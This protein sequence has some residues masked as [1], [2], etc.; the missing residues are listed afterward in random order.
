MRQ[1]VTPLQNYGSFAASWSASYTAWSPWRRSLAEQT[2]GGQCYESGHADETDHQLASRR[3]RVAQLVGT[4]ARLASALFYVGVWD[5]QARLRRKFTLLVR[6]RPPR[7][8]VAQYDV[9]QCLLRTSTAYSK[10]TNAGASE[11]TRNAWQCLA[12]SPR[13]AP[14]CLSL[15]HISEPTRPY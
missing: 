2:G 9:R 5:G 10:P 3:R 13:S 15:I 7:N 4:S 6:L 14:Q 11:K 8:A 1:L 12:Y